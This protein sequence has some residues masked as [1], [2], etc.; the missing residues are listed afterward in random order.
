MDLLTNALTLFVIAIIAI[1]AIT[2]IYVSRDTKTR[3]KRFII[4]LKDIG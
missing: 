3:K 1:I 4:H 2:M